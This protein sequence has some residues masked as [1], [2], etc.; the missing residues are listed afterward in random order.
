MSLVDYDSSS[1]DEDSTPQPL[2]SLQNL[3]LP[4]PLPPP[5]TASHSAPTSSQR[6]P[7]ATLLFSEPS[8]SSNLTT[9]SDHYSRVAAAMEQSAARKRDSNGSVSSQR[10]RKNPRSNVPHTRS[11]PDTASGLLVPPQ[12]RGRSNVV[13]QDLGALFLRR[14][15][16]PSLQRSPEQPS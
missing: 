14:N 6:L 13:T 3:S 15:A 11:V 12:L 1:D 10:V 8:F 4:S 2:P 16:N 5:V 9:G 7:D